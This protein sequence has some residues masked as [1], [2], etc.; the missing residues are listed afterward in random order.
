M[1][2][3][4]VARQGRDP[5]RARRVGAED[6]LEGAAAK[7]CERDSHGLVLGARGEAKQPLLS[8]LAQVDDRIVADRDIAEPAAR[9]RIARATE[10]DQPDVARVKLR[11]PGLGPVPRHRAPGVLAPG[12]LEPDL[13]A[14]EDHRHAGQG[15][16]EAEPHLVPLT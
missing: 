8:A 7:R 10:S 11:V 6:G 9:E 1:E 3:R 15:H 14:G 4:A 12:A 2:R 13:V 16:L 5:V